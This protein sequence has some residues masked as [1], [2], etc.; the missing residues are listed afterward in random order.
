M[1][2][3]MINKIQSQIINTYAIGT[4][5]SVLIYNTLARTGGFADCTWKITISCCPNNT[6]KHSLI[7]CYMSPSEQVLQIHLSVWRDLKE[8]VIERFH[9]VSGKQL[10]AHP[11]LSPSCHTTS[12]FAP[13]LNLENLRQTP[14]S[15][16][17]KSHISPLKII[18][19]IKPTAKA[20]SSHKIITLSQRIHG[21]SSNISWEGQKII[22]LA[23][24]KCSKLKKLMTA[25]TKLKSTKI[26]NTDTY[27][28]K[29]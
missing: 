3:M 20:T 15:L 14:L 7:C 29:T 1:H 16:V 17:P 12:I 27:I 18:F 22:N 11:D 6:M 8:T 10:H 9:R 19:L 28:K 26:G 24:I 25:V 5:N 21:K 23:K 13:S 4:E 2:E